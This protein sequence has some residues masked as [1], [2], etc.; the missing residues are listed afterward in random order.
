MGVGGGSLGVGGKEVQAIMYKISYKDILYNI[1]EYSQYSKITIM[2]Y[3]L[4]K[5]WI[6][7]LYTCNLYIMT[8]KYFNIKKETGP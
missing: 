4:L 7:T 2:E 3:N 6:I 1:R 8:N 5:M